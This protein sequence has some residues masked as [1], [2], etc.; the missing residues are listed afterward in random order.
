MRVHKNERK[1]ISGDTS[2]K[3][4]PGSGRGLTKKEY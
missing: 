3:W 2:Q 4:L 1:L